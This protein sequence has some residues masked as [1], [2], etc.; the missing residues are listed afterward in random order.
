MKLTKSKL[1]QLIL[2]M[3]SEE[4]SKAEKI[5]SMIKRHITSPYG[6]D[7]DFYNQ[8]VML[9]AS[10][11]LINEVLELYDN[12]IHMEMLQPEKYMGPQG[13]GPEDI[14]RPIYKEMKQGRDKFYEDVTRE[15]SLMENQK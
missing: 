3:M 9:T 1:K 4:K 5:F 14:M 6:D 2:E 10:S 15:M 12:Y 8:A 13:Y 11:N 7:V